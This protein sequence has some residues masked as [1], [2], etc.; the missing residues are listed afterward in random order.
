MATQLVTTESVREQ[1]LGT[2]SATPAV[3]YVEAAKDLPEVPV[4]TVPMPSSVPESIATLLKDGNTSTVAAATDLGYR[5][6]LVCT[7]ALF[8]TG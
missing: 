3:S 4:P 5:G 2:V 1:K 6:A 7:S 8:A